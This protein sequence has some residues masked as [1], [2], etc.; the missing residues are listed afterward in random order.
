MR[1]ILSPSGQ[2]AM[3]DPGHG[4]ASCVQKVLNKYLLRDKGLSDIKGHFMGE[5]GCPCC[6]PQRLEVISPDTT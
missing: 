4:T 3:S 1:Q 6:K 2:L 5:H